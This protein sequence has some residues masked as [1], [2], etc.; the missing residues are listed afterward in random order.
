MQCE[1]I[2]IGTELLLGQIVD[3][4]SSWIG[5]QLALAGID[6][7]FQTKVGDNL[8]RII[9]AIRLA[10]SRSDAVILCGGLGPTQ[11]DITR[12]AI[13]RVMGVKL[14]Q[15]EAIAERIR[16][17]FRSRN[18]PMPASN[19]RQAAVPEGASVIPQMPGTAPGLVC[20]VGNK[21]IY[22]VPGVPL[23][24]REMITGTVLPDL[25]Q[26]AGMTAVIKSRTL[27]TW[28]Q[29][30]SALAELL[31]GRV[32]ALDQAGNPTLAFLASGIEGIKVRITAKAPDAATAEQ[33]L[34][35]E[36]NHLRALLGQLLF[37][38]DGQTMES[39]VLDRLRSRGLTLGLA[40][41][42]TGGLM[43]SRLSATPGAERV[44][45]GAVVVCAD[46]LASGLLGV[47]TGPLLSEETVKAM[48]LGACRVVGAEVGLAA[49]AVTDPNG[50]AGYRLGTVFMGMALDGKAEAQRIRL[51]GRAEQIRQFTVINLLNW[52]R[53]KLLA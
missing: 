53:L 15:D 40:E 11:D 46:T 41:M 32:A 22:A 38:V 47:P 30:E 33:L 13:A 3:T 19:L 42:V 9:S 29:P 28:G 2:A 24:M 43:S 35:Q 23:E 45:R 49:T 44:F 17:I 37:G 14:V 48:A 34:A 8:E 18:R 16:G 27:R 31:A 20:P 6:S 12:E 26:R 4:N 52:L 36:E 10:L 25:Q 5:E 21:V 50:Q 7:H 39:V 1:I 51:P